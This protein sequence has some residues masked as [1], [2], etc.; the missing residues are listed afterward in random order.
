MHTNLSNDDD[1][2]VNLK[3]YQPAKYLLRVAIG[4]KGCFH[5]SF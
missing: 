2:V 5:Q 3:I 1:D 4:Y